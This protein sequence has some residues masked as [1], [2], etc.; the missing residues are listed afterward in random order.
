VTWDEPCNNPVSGRIARKLVEGV[1]PA[2]AADNPQDIK[3]T[4]QNLQQ[5]IEHSNA[6]PTTGVLKPVP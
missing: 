6:L 3:P 1:V 4:S 5:V 2:S